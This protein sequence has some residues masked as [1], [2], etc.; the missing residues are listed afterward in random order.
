MRL[1]LSRPL[2]SKAG[3]LRHLTAG[4]P[5]IDGSPVRVSALPALTAHGGQL[6]SSDAKGRGNAVYAASFIRERRIVLDSALLRNNRLLR[7]I[8][9][10]ELFHFVWPRLS[11]R[12]RGSYA[13]L[14]AAER[15]ARARG[16]LGESSQWRKTLASQD[17][18]HAKEYVCESFCDTAAYLYAGVAGHHW[19]RLAERWTQR[20]ALWFSQTFAD[21][22][23][24]T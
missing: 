21:G 8:V 6:L 20:R 18:R 3:V 4:L 7:L 11:N 13:E 19:F 12:V 14:L 10:H 22:K 2:Q 16:E 17:P 5:C 23:I 15:D 1:Q 24:R 9:V